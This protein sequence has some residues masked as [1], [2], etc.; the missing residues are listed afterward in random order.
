[1]REG[2]VMIHRIEALNFRCLRTIDQGLSHFQILVG[3]NASGKTTFLDVVGFLGDLVAHGP[4]YAV[5]ERTQNFQDLVWGRAGDRFDLAFELTIPL[6][7]R[8]KI[9]NSSCSVVRYEVAIGLQNENR[10]IS[11]L[12]ERV[13]FIK[14]ESKEPST[15][16]L[17]PRE[18][19]PPNDLNCPKNK[20]IKTVIN[21][22]PGGNDNFHSEVQNKGGWAPSFKLGPQKSALG[23]LPP[24]ES[25]F[26]VSTWLKSMLTEGVQKIT[27]NSLQM[28]QASPPGQVKGFKSD[29]SNI[30]WVIDNL[31]HTS[32]AKYREWIDHLRTALQDIEDIRIVERPDDKYRYM[33]IRY[34]GGLEIPSWMTSDG[35]L[36]LLALTLPAYLS[37]FSGIYLIE[38]PENGVHPKAV[39]TVCQSLSSVYGAQILMASHSP[40]ILSIVEP[41][42]ILCF[43]KTE[44]GAVDIIRGDRHPALRDWKKETDLGVL[45][46]GGVLG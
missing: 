13:L 43:S 24:D 5:R 38:E 3:P 6:Y 22:V 4:E 45:F 17:F 21:K 20:I 1:M 39:E 37:D 36:R 18:Q 2:G 31:K 29:G 14:E 11:I 9:F 26:P 34:S 42:D 27:L 10:E 41:S 12:G 16:T 30:P 28:R 23:N 40:V 19:I 33:M 25:K 44:S 35:T 7:L 8:D 46:A 32:E 15:P